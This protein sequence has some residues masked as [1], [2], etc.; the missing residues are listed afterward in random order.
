VLLLILCALA[1]AASLPFAR[2]GLVDTPTGILLRHTQIQIGGSFTGYSYQTA[3]S[4]SESD[5]AIAGHIE[6]GIFD[7]AQVGVTYLGAGGISGQARAIIMHESI[8]RPT[9]SIGVENLVGE[10]N[11]EFFE[12][13]SGALY[14]YPESQNMSAYIVFTKSLDNLA[15]APITISLGYGTGRFRQASD[16]PGDGI[17]NPLPGLFASAEFHPEPRLSIMLEWDGRDANL[18]GTYQVSDMVQVALAVA[19]F[20]QFMRGDARDQTDVMQSTKISL[21]AQIT[22]GPFLNRTTLQP[23]E[24]LSRNRD[25]AALAALEEAR[26]HALED[27]EALLRTMQ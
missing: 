27:I 25:E 14:E 13:D 21:G 16:T 17:E 7:R 23:I 1:G 10:E 22:L 8:Y 18:G 5:F 3:D 11:Y 9:I 12:S 15:R 2:Y 4:T 19:E 20:E 6:V 26:R 24:R